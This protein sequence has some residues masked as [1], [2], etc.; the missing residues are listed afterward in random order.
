MDKH[1]F[2]VN[3]SR[4]TFGLNTT[5][6]HLAVSY[7]YLDKIKY[8]LEQG[9]DINAKNQ[10]GQTPL[11]IAMLSLKVREDIVGYLR[12]R[13]AV[14]AMSMESIQRSNSMAFNFINFSRKVFIR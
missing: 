11:D 6:L 8:L 14:N 5:L 3:D 1:K 2:N 13:G 9:A 7:G 12:S 4:E 10:R